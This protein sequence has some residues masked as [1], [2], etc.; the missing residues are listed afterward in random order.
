MCVFISLSTNGHGSRSGAF[1][2][3]W[4]IWARVGRI[5][6]GVWGIAKA[7]ATT[8]TQVTVLGTMA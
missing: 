2:H 1:D 4:G 8:P 3:W 7:S 6:V 5:Q